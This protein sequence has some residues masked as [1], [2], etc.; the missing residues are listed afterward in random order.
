ME[1]EQSNNHK[2]SSSPA[3]AATST[4]MTVEINTDY[5]NAAR[6]P[7]WMAL[8]V[9]SAICLAAFDSRRGIFSADSSG[10]K[11]VLAVTLM[12]M[13]LSFGAVVMYLIMR[14]IFVGQVPE[15]AILVFLIACWSACLPTVMNRKSV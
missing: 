2:M 3:S 5:S 15:M 1:P 4:T 12:S 9:F 13:I 11:W 6:F 8:C 7:A 14:A 10:E